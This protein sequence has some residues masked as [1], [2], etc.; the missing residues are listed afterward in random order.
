MKILKIA[1]FALLVNAATFAKNKPAAPGYLDLAIPVNAINMV[2][3]H[4]VVAP[5]VAA[6]YYAYAMMSA[7]QIISDHN[8][9]IP[10][11]NSFVK[12]YPAVKLTDESKDADYQI[13][14]VYSIFETA[15]NLLPS[16]YTL[17][18]N[19]KDYLQ[20]L[21]KNG[22]KED[23]IEKAVKLAEKASATVVNFSKADNYGK[24]S[25]RLRYTPK[26]GE[27]YWYPTP[28]A[29]MDA[30]EP[31]WN[32]ITPLVID[33]CSQFKPIPPI[34]FS[35]DSTSKFYKLAK[36]VRDVSIHPSQEQLNIASF[37]DCN[38]FAVTTSGHMSIGYKKISPGGHW[39]N[40]SVLVLKKMNMGFDQS[41][42]TLSVVGIG[43]MDSFISCWDEKYRSNRIRPETYINKYM[44]INWKPLLQ[45]PPFPEYTSGHAVVSH[46]S[47]YLL[48]YLLGE[49]I[50]YTDNTE[51]PFGVGPRS[52]SSF[53]Q[54]AS[55]ASISRLYGGIHYRDSVDEGNKQGI[56]VANN[57]I[58][59]L[60]KAGIKPLR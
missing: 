49:K 14:A 58:D 45:T 23:R 59:K 53:K 38:P 4:D 26:Q 7:Y 44:D 3:I 42:L 10:A 54:A 51:V 5:P 39:M 36:E 20:L 6:R 40:I 41:I 12:K 34:P 37:W 33:S 29:Y 25:A 8:R 56:A 16:G 1:A 55:E 13:A 19:E 46:A 35:K 11:L 28:P 48:S 22:V 2:M 31:N 17:E 43:L 18:D 24:L 30:V 21:R 50:S 15:K 60:R 57:I 32:T 27:G 47:A 9:A 52:F